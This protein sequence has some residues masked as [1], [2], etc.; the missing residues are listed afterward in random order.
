MPRPPA[1]AAQ[2]QAILNETTALRG[3]IA[4][5]VRN[6]QEVEDLLQETLL[7]SLRI[8]KQREIDNPPAYAMQVAK[9][10]LVEF[11]QRRTRDTAEELTEAL[12]PTVSSPEVTEEG[13]RKLQAMVDILETLPPLRREVFSRRRMEGQS[14]EEIA[15]ELG[16]SVEAVKKHINRALV[17]LSLGLERRGW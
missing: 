2:E 4:A 12:H 16:L 13:M 17:D 6:P 5:R 10:V 14:R 7:R 1:P 15:R 11:W 3:Y 8:L 9:S